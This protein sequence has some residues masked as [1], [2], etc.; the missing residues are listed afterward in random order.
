M[1]TFLARK[2]K[3]FIDYGDCCDCGEP[4]LARKRSDGRMKT[5]GSATDARVWAT[6]DDDRRNYILDIIKG[7]KYRV[8]QVKRS[9]FFSYVEL[10]Y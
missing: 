10:R 8:S 2:E 6:R 1:T 9:P 4:E 5:Y 7:P 3:V